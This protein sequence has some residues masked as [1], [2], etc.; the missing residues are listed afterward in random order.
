MIFTIQKGI[1]HKSPSEKG[2]TLKG[3]KF[4]SKGSKFFPF[5]VDSFSEG[6]QNNG[7]RVSS[8]ESVLIPYKLL[9]LQHN[10]LPLTY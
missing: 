4:A 2:S 1:A 10:N 7:D 8:P 9:F 5:R 6:R 3:K